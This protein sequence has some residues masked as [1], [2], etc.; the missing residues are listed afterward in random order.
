M[1]HR[2]ITET[3]ESKEFF[4]KVYS[5]QIPIV[6]TC[7][8]CGKGGNPEYICGAIFQRKLYAMF[9][10]E[11]DTCKSCYITEY[12][13]TP[14][15]RQY[16]KYDFDAQIV[17]SYPQKTYNDEVKFSEHIHSISE[18]FVSVFNQSYKA[19]GQE[20]D[21]IAGAGFR[22]ALEILVKDYCINKLSLDSKVVGDK[23]LEGCIKLIPESNLRTFLLA[24][25][26]NGNDEVHYRRAY[27]DSSIDYLVRFI[28]YA[29]NLIDADAMIEEAMKFI[30][31]ER[32]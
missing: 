2:K 28:Y 12:D 23:S 21:D 5:V 9:F 25:K 16:A 29:V 31:P 7:P 22:K 13:L 8:R 17:A 27:E 1:K 26:T 24:A 3:V 14:T 32:T 10:C 15:N 19:Y 18:R 30:P 6:G 4:D 20:L 11:I